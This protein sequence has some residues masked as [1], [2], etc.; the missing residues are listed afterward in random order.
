MQLI[1]LTHF[2]IFSTQSL[3]AI[4]HLDHVFLITR[5]FVIGRCSF[6][7]RYI[8]VHSFKH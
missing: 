5:L 3:E 1:H 2:I 7:A 8:E 4:L 6:Q